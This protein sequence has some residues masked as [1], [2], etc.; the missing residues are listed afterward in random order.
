MGTVFS[1]T[2]AKYS[3]MDDMITEITPGHIIRRYTLHGKL[4]NDFYIYNV[5]QLTY[6]TNEL[7]YKSTKNYD[8]EGNVTSEEMNSMPSPIYAVAHCKQ[9]ETEYD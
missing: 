2:E 8:D 7:R 4:I 9:Y 1:F 5:E 6:E 3:I